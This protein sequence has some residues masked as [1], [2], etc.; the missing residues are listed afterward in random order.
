MNV[1][2]AAD[3][4]DIL[5]VVLFGIPVQDGYIAMPGFGDK[6]SDQQIADL[7]NYLRSSWGNGAAVNATAAQ[8]AALRKVPVE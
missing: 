5:K 7:A 8:V 2:L 6:L 4:N 1:V 3:A